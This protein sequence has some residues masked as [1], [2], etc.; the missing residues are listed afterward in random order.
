MHF[1]PMKDR[2][3]IELGILLFAV[4]LY[5]Q[6]GTFFTGWESGNVSCDGAGLDIQKTL[7]G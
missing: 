5:I 3:D 7:F 6:I 1:N 4:F 2:R